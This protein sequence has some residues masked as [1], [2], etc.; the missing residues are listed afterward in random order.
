MTVFYSVRLLTIWLKY[1]I[2][3]LFYLIVL[4]K[5]SS[6]SAASSKDKEHDSTSYEMLLSLLTE[7]QKL[8]E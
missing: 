7:A 3:L 6:M 5:Y 4:D 2:L 8:A 1:L